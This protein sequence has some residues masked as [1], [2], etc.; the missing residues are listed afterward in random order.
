MRVFS[1]VFHSFIGN[2]LSALMEDGRSQVL[3]AKVYSKMERPGDAIMSLQ[4]VNVLVM[5]FWSCEICSV[6]TDLHKKIISFFP[7]ENISVIENTS[8]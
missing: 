4:K 5:W 2:E 8:K 6:E 1:F 3:L 7:T